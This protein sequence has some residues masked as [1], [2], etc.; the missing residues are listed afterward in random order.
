MYWFS[1][2]FMWFLV[3]LLVGTGEPLLYCNKNTIVERWGPPSPLNATQGAPQ[4][5]SEKRVAHACGFNRNNEQ[6]A[7]EPQLLPGQNSAQVVRACG[8]QA[9]SYSFWQQWADTHNGGACRKTLCFCRCRGWPPPRQKISPQ[10]CKGNLQVPEEKIDSM[11]EIFSVEHVPISGYSI[12][13]YMSRASR[14][15]WIPGCRLTVY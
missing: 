11:A 7:C 4:L 2:F 6:L 9:G 8:S 12:L 14:F 3:I 1:V 15:S 13:I 5:Q 10:S